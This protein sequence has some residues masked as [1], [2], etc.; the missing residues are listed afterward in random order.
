[1]FVFIWKASAKANKGKKIIWLPLKQSWWK[2][3][4]FACQ[5]LLHSFCCKALLLFEQRQKIWQGGSTNVIM[6]FLPSLKKFAQ[7]VPL[8]CISLETCW[9]F[10]TKIPEDFSAPRR[11]DASTSVGGAVLEGLYWLTKTLLLPSMQNGQD[12]RRQTRELFLQCSL[13][14]Q[15][16]HRGSG[17][18]RV[19][20]IEEHR[21]G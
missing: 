7:Y 3:F 18:V 11:P 16:G 20:G 14:L 10:T 21:V 17:K 1:M 19:S 9:R 8:I 6:C 5:K 13:C 15:A 4:C 2:V 12:N